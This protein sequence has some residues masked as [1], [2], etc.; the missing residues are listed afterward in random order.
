MSRDPGACV[1][2]GRHRPASRWPATVVAVC[3]NQ[4]DGP[5][6]PRLAF[7]KELSDSTRTADVTHHDLRVLA[8][9]PR[10]THSNGCGEATIAAETCRN[11][12]RHIVVDLCRLRHL[13]FV[14]EPTA[15]L[16]ADAH[17]FSIPG[18]VERLRPPKWLQ[19]CD[20]SRAWPRLP[21]G[22]PCASG[23]AWRGTLAACA[24]PHGKWG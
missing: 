16:S 6:Q 23:L 24:L 11:S 10:D 2:D 4:R 1:R 9:L 12:R 19:R 18:L 15:P 14:S 17:W 22:A 5:E 8:A 3:P 21:R 13:K 20:C 7:A